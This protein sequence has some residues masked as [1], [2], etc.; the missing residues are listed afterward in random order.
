MPDN[1]Q[2]LGRVVQGPRRSI[3]R[4]LGSQHGDF[5]WNTLQ[6]SEPMKLPNQ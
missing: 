6:L 1:D 2:L 5:V 3:M 4:N